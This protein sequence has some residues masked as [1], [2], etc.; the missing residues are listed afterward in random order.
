MNRAVDTAILPLD[1]SRI[2]AEACFFSDLGPRLSRWMQSGRS[3]LIWLPLASCILGITSL[4]LG[5]FARVNGAAMKFTATSHN[6]PG[7]ASYIH[8]F[9]FL[10]E[11]NFAFW[12]IVRIPLLIVLTIQYT[13]CCGLT[14]AK[15][16]RI[17]FAAKSDR[18]ASRWVRDQTSSCCLRLLFSIMA[19]A[20]I[21]FNI[22]SQR[23]AL[24]DSQ[25]LSRLKDPKF[26][27]WDFGTYQIPFIQGAQT[28]FAY[29]GERSNQ[30]QWEFFTRTNRSA[31]VT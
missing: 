1:E 8:P 12:T 15:G 14:L 6:H 24:E 13:R 23:A 3:A 7:G 4:L 29:W 20:V 5:H 30:T 11:S 21:A 27:E 31:Y 26:E 10:A 2:E 19:I 18:L 22:Q 16:E 17:L 25:T 28:A 9:G